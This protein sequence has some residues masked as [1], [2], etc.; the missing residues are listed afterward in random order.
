LL[1]GQYSVG[2]T[3]F[4]EFML[5]RQFPGERVGPEPTTDKF[6]AI[7]HGNEDQ[8]IPGPALSVDT[9]RPYYDLNRFG[10]GFLTKFE[11]SLCDVDILRNI[12]FVDT[13]GILAGEKQ[14]SGRTYDFS[15]ISEWFISRADM[16]LLLFDAHKLDIS[17]EF[18]ATIEL[19]KGSEEKVRILLNKADQINT[20]QL[21]RVYGAL[22]WSLGKVIKAPEVLR[23]YIGSFWNQPFHSEENK[24]LFEAE[25]RDLIEDLLGLPRN[26]SVRKINEL[27]KRTRLVRSH[28][29]IISHLREKMPLML[30]KET[31]QHELIKNLGSVFKEI[32]RHKKIPI[33]DFPDIQFMQNK[34]KNH[35]FTLFEKES[36]R[37]MRQI[38]NA[39]NV[40]LPSLMKFTQPVK[41][42]ERNPFL[43]P[44]WEV[45]PEMKSSYDKL[46]RSLAQPNGR[47][48]GS[49]AREALLN[50]GIEV[51]YLRKI[52][53]LADIE[54]DGTLDMDEFALALHLTEIVKMGK[55]L[56]DTLP[57][58]LI[59]P[60]K[61]KYFKS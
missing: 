59:P 38:E 21:M 33:G 7:F 51:D 32:E 2:K 6:I 20:Q 48:I 41:T 44:Q 35:D 28:A 57:M 37:L 53:E 22:M 47:V 45:S 58:S 25:H 40:E 26:S 56:P 23:V 60:S 61:R 42:L 13:P 54:R 19:L 24:K 1:L 3:S 27:V 17:D 34:L 46:F 10:N 12:T 16:I 11:G 39:L 43:E 15:Q 5:K 4:I 14:R 36:E 29:Y 31:V 49:T 50:T 55:N 52:W 30:A 18:R 9:E 8:I